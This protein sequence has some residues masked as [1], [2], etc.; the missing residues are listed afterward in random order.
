MKWRGTSF[1]DL[2]KMKE[3]MERAWKNLSEQNPFAQER[4]MGQWIE[5]LPK[6]E[7]KGRGGL[8]SPSDEIIKS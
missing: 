6:F 8:R 4:E 3:K 7:G 2:Q 5:K 1:A